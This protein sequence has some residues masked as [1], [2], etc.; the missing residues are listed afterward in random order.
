M[1]RHSLTP[2]VLALSLAGCATATPYQ[3]AKD[4]LGYSE[5][6]LESN[7][8]RVMFAGNSSTPRQTVENYLLYRAAEITLNNG[9]DYFVIAD[10]AT[11][12]DTRYL[13]TFTG[14]AYGAYY[15]RPYWG[16]GAATTTADPI[17][18]YQAEANIIVFK[19]PK[20]ADNPK[21]F[22]AREL[23]TNLEAQIVRPQPKVAEN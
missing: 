22:D 11:N 13:Q 5:Q 4:G 2:V 7:R 3:P 17:T 19:G 9:Y 1:L 21:A 14:P 6:K 23:K 20:P 16:V 15:W 10:N 8:Y 12:A 18:E